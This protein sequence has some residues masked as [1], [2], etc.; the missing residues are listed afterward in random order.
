MNVMSQVHQGQRFSES[1][2]VS[3]QELSWTVKW[4]GRK[5]DFIFF[6]SKSRRKYSHTN[7]K[8]FAMTLISQDDHL[9][10]GAWAACTPAKHLQAR[11]SQLMCKI[12]VFICF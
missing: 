10:G 8:N 4:R 2:K 6:I 5:F 1:L 12:I 3:F 11:F 9:T 7:S